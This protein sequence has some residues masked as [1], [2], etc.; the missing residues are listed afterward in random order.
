MEMNQGGILR[1]AFGAALFSA[2][3][4][5]ASAASAGI[6]VDGT[7]DAAYGPPTAV[8]GYDP[9]APESNFQTPGTASDAIGYS[10]YEASD[11]QNAY[12]FLQTN[13]GGGGQSVGG[14]TNL[15]FDLDPQNHNGSDLG[16]EIGS[17]G[18]ADAFIPGVNGSVAVT[19]QI[20]G[21]S[22]H[23]EV[24]IPISFFTKAIA[25]LDYAAGQQFI[26]AANNKLVLS[27][28]Q[29][30]GY[31]VA[32]GTAYGDNRLGAL[33]LAVAV[34]EPAT[35]ALL[36]TALFAAGGFGWKRKKKA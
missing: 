36:G 4:F 25:G 15:Y 24:A 17:N 20:A 30:F 27:L 28:S 32:G 19:L 11:S 10:I 5:A 22:T 3:M 26:T 1:A 7:L 34:P 29:S 6:I 21:D 35:V 13:P 12:F 14:F 2:A 9:N 8:V 33:D 31:S 16:F 18:H 23:I